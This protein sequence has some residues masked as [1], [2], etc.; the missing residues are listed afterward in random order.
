[1]Q[2]LKKIIRKKL[3]SILSENGIDNFYRVYYRIRYPKDM[4]KKESFGELN[5]SNIIYIIRPRTDCTEG[6][7][8]LFMNVARNLHYA[9][10]QGYI[11]V[12]DFK[13][14]KTQYQC[15]EG[16]K[17]NV[18][19][20]YFTQ[21][22]DVKLDEAYQSK[23]VILSGLEIQWFKTELFKTNYENQALRK[24]HD[25]IFSS[26]D[27]NETVKKAVEDEMKKSGIVPENTLAL[28]MR[29]TD[30]TSL[31]PPGHPVQ[32]SVQQAVEKINE[33][34]EKHEEIQNIFLVTEDGKIYEEI[35]NIYKEKCIITS[36]DSFI[37]NYDGKNYL[38]HDESI[39]ELANSAYERG[40]NYLIKL[41]ILSKCKFFVGGNTMG[42]WAACAFSEKNFEDKHIFDLGM[43]GK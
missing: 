23:N 19:D 13:N 14:Y 40:L 33:F 2:N 31:K 32:P 42:S 29:G 39:K 38:S 43:Y 5:A 27:F 3:F 1:M 41:I 7:M 9:K 21:P 25:E 20:W 17:T 37:Q 26:I 30:Y 34:L 24:L 18:W 11:S 4:S 15:A 22:S 16:T 12:V 6:L 8:S 28:Y 35:Q 36:F 10:Q